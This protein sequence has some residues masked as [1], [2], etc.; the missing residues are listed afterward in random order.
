MRDIRYTHKEIDRL[1]EILS[2]TDLMLN[3]EYVP[4]ENMSED[5]HLETVFWK[6]YPHGRYVSKELLQK[7]YMPFEDLPL[8]VGAKSPTI[9]SIVKWRLEIGK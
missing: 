5:T 4:P 9:E 1:V 7:A 2:T 6:I 8:Y 3:S